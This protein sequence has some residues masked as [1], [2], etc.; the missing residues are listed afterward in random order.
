MAFTAAECS[1]YRS[2]GCVELALQMHS[3]LSFP[4]PQRRKL[5]LTATFGSV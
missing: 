5:K 3:S 1:L 2:I 4:P